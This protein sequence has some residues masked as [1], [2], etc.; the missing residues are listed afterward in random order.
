MKVNLD[1]S[2]RQ[3]AT[4][5]LFDEGWYREN[6][7]IPQH[8]DA[9]EHYLMEGYKKGWNPSK[10]FSSEE[11]YLQN[12]DVRWGGTNPLLHFEIEGNNSNLYKG[13]VP[14]DILNS[15]KRC[16]CC[17]HYVGKY[18]PLPQYYFD[19]AEKYHAKSAKDEMLNA[20]EYSCP[21]CGSADRD[22]A[23]AVCMERLLPENFAGTV[24]DIAPA[25]AIKNFIARKYPAA[26]Y[27]TADLYME[28]VDYRLDVMDMKE[29]ADNSVDFFICSHVLE[30]VRDDVK[31][32]KELHR[33]LKHDGVGILV[34]PID[35]LCEQIDED[36]ELEDIGERWRRFGQDDHVRRYSKKG[37]INRLEQAGL[38]V[39]LATREFF[40]KTAMY[41]NAL[42]DTAT[43]YL[44]SK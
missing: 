35:L 15:Y 4:S 28:N 1:W 25:A 8:E 7:R 13:R 9:A 44:V 12:P 17:G 23:Y 18:I 2:V 22:R 40:G 32:M 24:L 10:F 6:Y 30:H 14:H 5:P 42:T 36:P 37:Y 29:I 43:V 33:I 39:T 16:A 20:E 31:A 21:Y 19:M 38:T 3:I 11:Y 34:V 26:G 41:E 27:K